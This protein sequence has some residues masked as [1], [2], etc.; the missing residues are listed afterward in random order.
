MEG[1]QIHNGNTLN[2]P[3][4]LYSSNAH[5]KDQILSDPLQRVKTRASLKN[6]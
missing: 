1:S 5:P 2:L 4:D 6:I 3:R